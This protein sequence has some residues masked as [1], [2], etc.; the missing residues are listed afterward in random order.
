MLKTT[1]MYACLHCDA[2]Q[3]P[4]TRMV[5]QHWLSF[6]LLLLL[7][8][9]HNFD[10]RTTDLSAVDPIVLPNCTKL[11]TFC[12]RF[13]SSDKNWRTNA[14]SKKFRYLNSTIPFDGLK[15]TK[16]LLAL[17][18]NSVVIKWDCFRINRWWYSQSTNIYFIHWTKSRALL[19][20]MGMLRQ[21]LQMVRTHYTRD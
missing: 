8:M 13:I 6:E 14:Q 10:R 1:T 7:L 20:L 5:N 16:S 19:T 12:G 18:N 17:V 21:K 11:M 4:K 2:E 9:W 3:M 15:H